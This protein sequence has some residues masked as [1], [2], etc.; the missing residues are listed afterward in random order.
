MYLIAH[1]IIINVNSVFRL[2]KYIKKINLSIHLETKQIQVYNLVKVGYVEEN[3]ERTIKSA[4]RYG[5]QDRSR[6]K[7][8]SQ[9][10]LRDF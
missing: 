7:G 8:N 3:G 6:W 4:K 2:K 10:T 9:R 1:N 5:K